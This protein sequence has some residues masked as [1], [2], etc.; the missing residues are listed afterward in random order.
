MTLMPSKYSCQKN[1]FNVNSFPI[2]VC[3]KNVMDYTVIKC[4]K[5]SRKWSF[6]SILL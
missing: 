5:E 1:Y 2:S 3:A 6:F 4:H